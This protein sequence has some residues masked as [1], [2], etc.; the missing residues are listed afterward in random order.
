MNFHITPMKSVLISPFSVPTVEESAGTNQLTV[1]GG[2]QG[3]GFS[4]VLPESQFKKNQTTEAR[5]VADETA[6][7]DGRESI[8]F[9]TGRACL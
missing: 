4:S 8:C 9:F 1:L 6:R 7:R 3:C 2:K 5:L